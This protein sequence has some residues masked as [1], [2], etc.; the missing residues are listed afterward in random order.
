MCAPCLAS[1]LPFTATQLP[2]ENQAKHGTDKK[3]TNLTGMM[4]AAEK[5][6]FRTKAVRVINE[7]LI[8]VPFTSNSTSYN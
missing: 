4:E 5:L 2:F 7:T 8:E 6:G 3:G 1:V